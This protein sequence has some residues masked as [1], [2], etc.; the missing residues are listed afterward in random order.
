[1]R[2]VLYDPTPVGDDTFPHWWVFPINPAQADSVLKP[3]NFTVEHTAAVNGNYLL[4]EGGR[5]AKP[6]TCRGELLHMDDVDAL[7]SWHGRPYKVYLGDDLGRL[8]LVK[9]LGVQ[10]TPVRDTRWPDHQSYVITCLMYGR[11]N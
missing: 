11:A 2:W 8:F 4:F 5:I 10:T 3:R 7:R 6:W 9:I 1:M